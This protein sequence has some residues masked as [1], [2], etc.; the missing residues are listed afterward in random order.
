MTH[1]APGPAS[2]TVPRPVPR[3]IECLLL[4]AG[5]PLLLYLDTP[6][7][8]HLPKIPVLAASTLLC[9][10]LL[11]RDPAFQ[12]ARLWNARAILSEDGTA[13]RTI[14]WRAGLVFLLACG[15]VALTDP[16]GLFAFPRSK[17]VVWL[18]VCLLYPWLSAYPQELVY[19]TF[20]HH[21]YA[22]LFPGYTGRIAASALAFGL[23][24]VIFDN[25]WAPAL[26]TAG[27]VLFARTYE[28]TG[29]TAAV[30]LEH[31][32]YGLAVF[33]SGLGKYFYEGF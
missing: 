16:A 31:A 12:R 7:L 10:A 19:R 21:R 27:G 13:L 33:T 32:L 1:R 23:M 14:L 6:H 8:P 5:M 20:F 11:W 3:A 15:L 30:G 26:S 29:S 17:P 2:R 18:I 24:H 9:L 4:F 28:R 25:Y 22:V